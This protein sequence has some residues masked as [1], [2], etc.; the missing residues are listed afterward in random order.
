[1]TFVFIVCLFS[2]S[3]PGPYVCPGAPIRFVRR[4]FRFLGHFLKSSKEGM[5][6]AIIPKGGPVIT[7]H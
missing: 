2:R 6:R 5:S 3:P 4:Q 7:D 1:M